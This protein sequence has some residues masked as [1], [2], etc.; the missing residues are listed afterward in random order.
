MGCDNLKV[1]L[2]EKSLG[3]VE[4]TT[5]ALEKGKKLSTGRKECSE[6]F[7]VSKVYLESSGSAL[8]AGLCR[9]TPTSQKKERRRRKEKDKQD[10]GNNR[11]LVTNILLVGGGGSLRY[12]YS[13]CFVVLLYNFFFHNFI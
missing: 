7:K 2:R 9:E 3:Q 1:A 10:D 8:T 13:F 11:H 5:R 12:Q 4:E 6:T